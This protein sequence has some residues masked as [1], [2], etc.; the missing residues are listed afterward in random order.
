MKT[1]TNNIY[2]NSHYDIFTII[3]IKTI[4]MR[5]QTKKYLQEIELRVFTR[6]CTNK[7]LR[8]FVLIIFERIC[9]DNIYRNL[10]K[11]YLRTFCIL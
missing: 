11:K 7:Y 5:I 8:E 9:T 1:R 4:F 2:D 3:Y 10:T 6:I